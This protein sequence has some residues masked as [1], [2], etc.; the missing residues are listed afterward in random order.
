MLKSL[1]KEVTVRT[2]GYASVFS[3]ASIIYMAG[4]ERIASY[5]TNFLIH[6]TRIATD[7]E[8]STNYFNFLNNHLN[9]VETVVKDLFDQYLTHEELN[10]ILKM[11]KDVYLNAYQANEKGI[12]T[13]LGHVNP[14]EYIILE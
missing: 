6:T 10:Q 7:Y 5:Y 1:Q 14:I 12:V 3:S 8:V 9:S 13:H 11:G 4:Q 2:I